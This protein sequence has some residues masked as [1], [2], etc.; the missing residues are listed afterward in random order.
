MTTYSKPTF[1]FYVYAFLRTD[2][3]PYYIGKG[4]GKRA[5]DHRRRVKLPKD[6]SH[7]IIC[8]S[9]LSD[10]GALALERRLIRWYGR[11]DNGTG[12]LRN[13][14]D[15]GEGCQN[16]VVTEE[17]LDNL[18]KRMAGTGNHMYGKEPWNKGLTKENSNTLWL[19]GQ[20]VS[21]ARSN[22]DTRGPNNHFFGKK[23]S[24]QSRSKMRAPRK[25]CSKIGK[26]ERSEDQRD[27]ARLQLQEMKKKTRP[28]DV[29]GRVFNLGNYT[30]HIR[31]CS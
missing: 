5:W 18:S 19:V 29:C 13:M 14:T 30:K 21:V 7:I 24:E 9:N 26:Y 28:C 22:C 27:Q 3:T 31:K 15:G 4:C 1:R 25:D 6:H 8:E 12:I 11:V 2:G 16:R 10:V 17:Y 20:K 23:H